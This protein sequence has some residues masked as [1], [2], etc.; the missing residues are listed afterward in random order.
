MRY[1]LDHL[2]CN[3]PCRRAPILTVDIGKKCGDLRYRPVHHV[4]TVRGCAGRQ[5][6]KRFSSLTISVFMY[7]AAP[8][9]PYSIADAD[10]PPVENEIDKANSIKSIL[11]T[12]PMYPQQ[13][14]NDQAFCDPFFE[15]IK[16]ARPAIEY[17]EPILRTNDPNH[18]GLKHY[19]RCDDY[20]GPVSEYTYNTIDAIGQKNFR[21]YRIDLDNNPKN[22]TE[23][24]IYAEVKWAN[25]Y[26]MNQVP[27]YKIIDLKQCEF[28]RDGAPVHQRTQWDGRVF[29]NYNALIRYRQQYYVV[30]LHTVGGEP[31]DPLAYRLAVYGF[32]VNVRQSDRGIAGCAWSA[33]KHTIYK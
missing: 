21:L 31:H 8:L 27:G 11:Q 3:A 6:R 24:V 19:H 22:G 12:I 18:P 2:P 25:R 7:I 26:G 32:K 14:I 5:M 29:D 33:F 10:S 30:D 23:E 28:R 9:F 20:R 13:S 1:C 4:P 15:A 16:N 17:V